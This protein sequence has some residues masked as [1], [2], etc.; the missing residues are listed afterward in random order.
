MESVIISNSKDFEV[1]KNKIL[2]GGVDKL[3]LIADFD[4]SLTKQF[5]NGKRVPSLISLL[6]DGDYISKEYARKAHELYDKYR[7]IEIS[8]I[9]KEEKS[10]FM[11]EW[12]KKHF[13]LLAVC[14]LNLEIIKKVVED[15]SEK[16]IL[17][18]RDFSEDLL[19]ILHKNKIPLIIMSAST[20]DIIQELLLRK[21]IYFENMHVIANFLKFDKNGQVVGVKEPIIHSMNK[22]EF[23]VK[24]FDFYYKLEKRKNVILLG[25]KVEDIDMIE[26]FDYEC[27]LKIGFLNERVEEQLED[28]KKN[29]DVVILNDGSMKFVLDLIKEIK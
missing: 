16:K 4:G 25:D 2:S 5:V 17:E 21:R 29:F 20:G 27:L 26:G 23:E 14:G 13:E 9:S 24:N 3:H 28:F 22:K 6:R 8:S 19:K 1:K 11:H 10:K 7:P 15:I 18:M 12:W